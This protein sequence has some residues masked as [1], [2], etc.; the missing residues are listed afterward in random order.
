M[1]ERVI[2]ERDAAI[3]AAARAKA[4]RADIAAAAGVTT[5]RVQQVLAESGAVR[6]YRRQPE[7]DD[8]P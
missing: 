8:S 2:E 5:T 1:L 3:V 4:S 7:S 6:P